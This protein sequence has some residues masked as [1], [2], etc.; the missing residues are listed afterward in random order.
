MSFFKQMPN[1][2]SPHRR[3]MIFID[4]ENLT[5]S[6]QKTLISNQNL[7]PTIAVTHLKDTYVWHQNS[8]EN[9]KHEILRAS[10]YT[11]TVGSDE[12]LNEISKTIKQLTFRTDIFSAL[13]R[14]LRPY[15]FKKSKQETKSKGVDI[16]MTVDILAN[17]YNDNTDTI[18]LMTG[19]GDF[20]PLIKEIS[21]AGKQIILASFNCGLNEK[22]LNEVDHYYELDKFYFEEKIK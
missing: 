2:T 18:L 19:D 21:H 7:I 16:Q 10:Y 8:V 14:N 20:L 6:Y 15:V 22:L 12:K 17:V 13:P 4:G 1:R 5:F 9:L 11:F 3:M